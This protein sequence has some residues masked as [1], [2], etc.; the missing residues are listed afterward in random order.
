MTAGVL[1]A[2]VMAV[3]AGC[4]SLPVAAQPAAPQAAS[5]RPTPTVNPLF[6]P[7]TRPVEVTPTGVVS[8]TLSQTQILRRI[9]MEP[10]PVATVRPAQKIVETPVFDD[11]LNPNWTTAYSVG[12]T[13]FFTETERVFAGTGIRVTPQQDFG[14][15]LFAV[16]QNT[17]EQYELDRV[18]G[19]SV[20]INSGDQPL[21]PNNLSVTVVGSN[22]YIYWRAD[23]ES[24]KTDETHFF[25]ESRLYYLGVQN[26]VPPHTWVEAVVWLDEL[27]YEPEY[28]YVTGIYIKNDE[29][30]RRT[31]YVDQINL[32]MVE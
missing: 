14:M 13:S 8:G 22:D 17:R 2:G 29:W 1:L 31:F 19:V 32:L 25:S 20:W 18:A 10:T 7:Q 15:L 28:K 16:K 9:F 4:A 27:P 11:K 26:V 30:F 12:M 6:A 24:V 21:D 5:S 3:A 23:D